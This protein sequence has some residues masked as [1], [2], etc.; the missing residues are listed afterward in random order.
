M[1]F[2]AEVINKNGGPSE[3]EKKFDSVSGSYN[4]ENITDWYERNGYYFGSVGAYTSDTGITISEARALESAAVYAVIKIKSEDMG[5]LPFFLYRAS[6][7]RKTTEKARDHRLWSVLHGLVNPDVSSG[8]FIEALTA[9]SE[10]CGGGFARIEEWDSGRRINLIPWQ[11]ADVTVDKDKKSNVVYIHKEGTDKTYPGRE[12]FHLRGF[13]FDCV[14]GD[15]ILRRARHLLGLTLGSQKFAGKVFSN[16]ILASLFF[17]HPEDVGPEGVEGIENAYIKKRQGLEKAGTPF[18]LQEG[19]KANR[20]DP[21]MEKMQLIQLRKFQVAE[22][23]RIWR[24]PLYKLA[25]LDRAIQSNIEQQAIEYIQHTLRPIIR[26]WREAVHRCLL[27]RDEQLEDRLYAE[28]NV[29]AL[30]RGDFKTQTE[31][32]RALLEKGVY[33]INEVRRWFNLNPVEGGDD[34]R[35]Q[36][37][38]QAISDSAKL[39]MFEMYKEAKRLKGLSADQEAVLERL[40]GEVSAVA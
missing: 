30:L 16:D 29:E 8:E 2:F 27:T 9:H 34:H 33:S 24:M 13:T 32:F 31:G 6:E 35:V 26:R 36:L 17:E 18:I 15:R 19:M 1:G 10:L 22:V 37:N 7:D 3:P 40:E 5:S 21:D 11:P 12:V 14:E 23:C 20:Q 39:L 4:T 25:E 38:T 28:H